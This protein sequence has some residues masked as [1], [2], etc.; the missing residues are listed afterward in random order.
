MIMIGSL[1]GSIIGFK[2]GGFFGMLF[3]AFIGAKAEVWI[4]ENLLG[5]PSRQAQ[6]QQAYF[7]ALFTSIGKLAKVDGIVTA[8][9]IRKC[10]MIMQK[11]QLSSEQRKLAINYFNQGKQDGFDIAPTIDMFYRTSGRSYSIKQMFIEMLLEVASAEN[12]INLAEWKLLLTICEHLRF[13]QQLFVTLVK[14]RGFNVH[15]QY[16]S[17]GSSS[18]QKQ[19]Q[20]WDQ[21]KPPT[22]QHQTNSYEVLGVSQTDS[23]AVI[24]RAYKKLMSSH[25]PDKL[26]AKGLPPEMIEIAKNKTQ[27]IQAAWEDVKQRRGF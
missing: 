12:R 13:P 1:I 9:E 26:I 21:W 20:Q 10:E 16:S 19:Y 18:S 15:S 22:Q 27:D 4:G 23:K 17:S 25:H 7:Q 24:R 8:D 5:K 3:G 11:M 2:F 6:V 14:M